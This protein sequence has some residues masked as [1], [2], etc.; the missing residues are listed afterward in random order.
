MYIED[1]FKNSIKF[2]FIPSL[3]CITNLIY[4]ILAHKVKRL[5]LYF[6][7]IGVMQ[8]RPVGIHKNMNLHKINRFI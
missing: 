2:L 6:N 3:G 4:D 7:F 1:N 8:L 5:Y